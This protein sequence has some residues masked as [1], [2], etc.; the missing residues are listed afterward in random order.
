MPKIVALRD[1]CRNVAKYIRLVEAG[2]EFIIAEGGKPVAKMSRVAA[3]GRGAVRPKRLGLA[4]D[5][6]R[7]R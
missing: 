7:S 5:N 3:K 1:A 4:R 2:A 6:K